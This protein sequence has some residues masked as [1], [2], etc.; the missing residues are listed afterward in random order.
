MKITKRVFLFVAVN[1]LIITT[2]SI[3]MSVLGVGD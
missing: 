2:I 3:A 1:I